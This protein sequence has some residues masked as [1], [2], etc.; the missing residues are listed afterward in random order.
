M[1]KNLNYIIL[2]ILM[3]LAFGCSHLISTLI[4]FNSLPAP[5]GKF[6]IGTSIYHWK[7]STRLEW[8][9]YK[10]TDFRELMVQIWYPAEAGKNIKKVPYMDNINKRIPEISKQIGIPVFM[11]KHL[12]NV[13]TN[14]FIDPKPI[15]GK[16]P[17]LIFSHGLG[18][19][20]TQNTVYME[21][22]ASNGYAVIAMDH[23]YDANITIYPDGEIALYSSSLPENT[24]D[25]LALLIRHKQL[26][27]RSADVS[28]VI[29]QLEKLNNGEIN[30]YFKENP[31]WLAKHQPLLY[32]H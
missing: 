16:L 25:S 4:P 29:N 32:H 30:S 28:Y 10:K 13:T 18:G 21:M 19:M 22:L 12:S 24:S 9:T 31:H 2:Y 6:H 1:K 7:D 3:L 20:R 15:E 27:T 23:P 11:L 17:V 14:S 8:F 5:E 26:D